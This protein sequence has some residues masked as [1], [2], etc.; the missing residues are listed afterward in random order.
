MSLSSLTIESNLFRDVRHG[1][2]H[3][4]PPPLLKSWEG[5]MPPHSADPR[6]NVINSEMSDTGRVTCAPPPLLK[7]WEGCAPPPFLACNP[8][9]DV[10]HRRGHLCPLLKSWEGHVLSPAADPRW[11]LV[12]HYPVSRFTPIIN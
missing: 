2:G 5:H 7:L 10:L 12:L 8:F 3:L 4:H 11:L 9:R 1:P 6:W